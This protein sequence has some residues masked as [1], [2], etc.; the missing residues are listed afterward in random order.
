[1]YF[2]AQLPSAWKI[3][4]MNSVILAAI[5][6]LPW[7]SSVVN[8]QT[9]IERSQV[10]RRSPAQV[11]TGHLFSSHRELGLPLEGYEDSNSNPKEAAGKSIGLQQVPI[12]LE[13]HTLAAQLD[14]NLKGQ[15]IFRQLEEGTLYARIRYDFRDQFYQSSRDTMA[16]VRP[17][18]MNP[19]LEL[20]GNTQTAR[21]LKDYVVF[22]GI[23]AFFLSRPETEGLGQ[24]YQKAVSAVENVAR[25]EQRAPEK[26]I[27]YSAGVNPLAFKAWAEIA[28]SKSRW[29]L[30]TTLEDIRSP[31]PKLQALHRFG[32]VNQY[33]LSSVYYPFHQVMVPGF[34]WEIQKNILN[35]SVGTELNFNDPALT[36][37][38]VTTVSLGLLF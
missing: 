30:S 35:T 22:K 13:E 17:V 18:S 29:S 10:T 37:N 6:T 24:K 32:G 4:P 20:S 8:K 36:K 21:A 26:K 38:M 23:P 27:T 14:L 28:D 7:P 33:V 19:E 11:G 1:M 5:F 15:P 31:T 25:V 3:F 9:Q 12:D 2:C 34:V 16:P